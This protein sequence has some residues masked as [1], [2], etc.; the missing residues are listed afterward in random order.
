MSRQSEEFIKQLLVFFPLATS[1]Y[2]KSIEENG[3]L[4]ETVVIEDIF[5]PEIITLL[6]DNKNTN[7]LSSIFSYFE[8]VAN[9]DDEQLKNIF[10]ITVLEVLGNDKITLK[11]ARE[12]MG[13]KT[14]KLQLEADRALGRNSL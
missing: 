2:R 10:I 14:S 8:T 12:Y 5:M 11:R 9:C 1:Q 4:L 3:E 13:V 7:L 6:K